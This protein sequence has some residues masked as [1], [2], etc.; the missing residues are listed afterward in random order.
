MYVRMARF[1][2]GTADDIVAEADEVRR[3][4]VAIGRG[5][6]GQYFAKELTDRV[7]RMEILVDREQGSVTILV[8]CDSQDAAREVERIMDGMS[9]RH[10]GW[11]KRVSSDVFEVVL[12]ESTGRQAV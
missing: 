3:D 8:Y 4:I 1:E 6:K 10:G 11:G 12:D 2:G 7:G 9:P 5:E